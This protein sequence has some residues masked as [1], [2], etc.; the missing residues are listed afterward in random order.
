[1]KPIY[2][3]RDFSLRA[4]LKKAMWCVGIVSTCVVVTV[5]LYSFIKWL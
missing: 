2:V 4:R 1:M 3:S 5:G